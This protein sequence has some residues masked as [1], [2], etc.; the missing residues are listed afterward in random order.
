MKKKLSPSD[1]DLRL[2]WSKKKET[3]KISTSQRYVFS[4]ECNR[5]CAMDGWIVLQGQGQTSEVKVE[6]DLC[7]DS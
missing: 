2:F 6:Y 4:R 3:K 5:L 1:G 7:V